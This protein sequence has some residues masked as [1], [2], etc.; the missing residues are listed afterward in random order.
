MLLSVPLSDVGLSVAPAAAHCDASARVQTVAAQD[1]HAGGAAFQPGPAS[2]AST[3]R[4]VLE[5][6]KAA[7]GHGIVL[8]TSLNTR[9]VPLVR[10][11]DQALAA[12]VRIGLDALI[13]EDEVVLLSNKY[14][15]S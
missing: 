11:A 6:I 2:D 7:T 10:T 5:V 13:V 3:Y 9:G 14:A 15:T 8:D 1:S 4:R 12:A